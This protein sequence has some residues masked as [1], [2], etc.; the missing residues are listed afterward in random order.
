MYIIYSLAIEH[1]YIKHM[2]TRNLL[3]RLA[4]YAFS[5]YYHYIMP[6]PN[7]HFSTSVGPQHQFPTKNYQRNTYDICSP[8]STSTI[9]YL[10][11]AT[12]TTTQTHGNN[13]R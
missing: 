11:F 4:S 3:N 9:Q 5:S 7:Q 2:L 6:L 12:T 10:A 1:P 8:I 13:V